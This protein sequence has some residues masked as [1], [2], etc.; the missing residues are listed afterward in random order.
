MFYNLTDELVETKE[1]GRQYWRAWITRR[2]DP[3]SSGVWG[4]IKVPREVDFGY[5]V[6]PGVGGKTDEH[7]FANELQERGVGYKTSAKVGG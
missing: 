5:I 1:L 2:T 7:A 4:K 3:A 6:R